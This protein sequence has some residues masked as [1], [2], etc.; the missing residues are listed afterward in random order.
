MQVTIDLPDQ[1]AR[2][3]EGQKERLA[4]IIDRGLQR[5]G[6]ETSAQWR[7]VIE[8]L[9]NGPRPEQIVAFR[10]SQVNVER[11]REL[12]SRNREAQ[13]TEAE[14]AE[15]DEMEHINQLMMLLKAEARRILAMPGEP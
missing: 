8:F 12:L 3:L 7:E 6:D 11:S 14:E 10:P 5:R 15:L 13:L 1:V 9:A 4:E 2:R